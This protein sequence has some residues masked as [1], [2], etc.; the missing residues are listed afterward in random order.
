MAVNRSEQLHNLINMSLVTSLPA[1]TRSLFFRQRLAPDATA[2]TRP[3]IGHG[4]EHQPQG[5][6]RRGNVVK[7]PAAACV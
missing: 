4:D 1:R 7:A 2:R 3:D 6:D 5:L